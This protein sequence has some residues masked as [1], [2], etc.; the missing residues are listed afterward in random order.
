MT[1]GR[2]DDAQELLAAVLASVP[3]AIVTADLDVR[4]RLVNPAAEQ[5]LGLR[6]EEIR[7]RDAIETLIDPADRELARGWV[8]RLTAGEAVPTGVLANLMRGDGSRFSAEV[9]VCPIR[10]AAGAM[11]GIVGTLQ[12]VTARLAAEED[13]ATLRAIVDAATE[14]IVGVDRMGDILFFSPSAERLYGWRA[15]EVIGKPVTV[16]IAEHQLDWL[17]EVVEA[18][19]SGKSVHRE[20]VALRRDGSHLEAELNASPIMGA[21]GRVRGTALIVLD[22]SE[23]RRAQRMLDRIVEQAPTS[24]AVKDLEGRYL[25]YG[26]RG[27]AV[28]GRRSEDFIGRTDHEVFAPSVAARLVELDR[29]VIASGAPLTSEETL[30]GPEGRV[31]VFVTTRFPLP[32]PYGRIEAIGLIAAD[33]TEIRRA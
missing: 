28:I 1:D 3:D 11:V 29:R 20:G 6:A 25:L 9:S 30:R 26:E 33:V 17:P 10:D 18:L 27:A 23:R 8:D 5:L 7:G 4:I 14:A 22:I 2:G 12:D 21:D 31:Y 32:G 19:A 13:A 24:I 15:E 16:L